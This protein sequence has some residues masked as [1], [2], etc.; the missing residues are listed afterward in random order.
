[1]ADDTSISFPA[2]VNPVPS[3]TIVKEQRIGNHL[4]LKLGAQKCNKR[5]KGL[6]MDEIVPV[7]EIELHQIELRYAHTRINRQ[8]ALQ[9]LLRSMM[10]YGQLVPIVVTPPNQE[11]R[12]IL[13]D[14][15][16]RVRTLQILG[17][18]TVRAVIQNPDEECAVFSTLMGANQRAFQAVEEG[19][20]FLE[21]RN[22]FNLSL[23]EIGRRIGK[24][25]SYVK[26]RLDLV[27]EL[28]TDVLALVLEGVISSWSAQRVLT[29]LARAN[30]E[31]AQRLGAFLKQE[32]VTTRVLVNFFN[33]YQK[34]NRAVRERMIAAPQMFIK[35]SQPSPI[36]A[37]DG[38]DVRFKKD[39][40]IIGSMLGRL[41]VNVA[42]VFT[43]DQLEADRQEL[44]AAVANARLQMNNLE[45]EIA[46]RV[47]ASHS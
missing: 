13:I 11:G 10:Q 21:L 33:H 16:L 7:I 41:A 14:G 30:A 22:R 34:A 15:Y 40:L 19:L 26:R 37:A 42:T 31:H 4:I 6:H 2:G 3:V 27:Q 17:K 24:D 5:W 25:K 23:G 20:I 29:P 44:M 18:D 43:S 9:R 38:P 8:S 45:E 35:A 47:N 32:E 1:M 12:Y 46:R 36:M 28:P 39:L